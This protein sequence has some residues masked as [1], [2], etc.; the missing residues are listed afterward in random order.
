MNLFDLQDYTYVKLDR[1]DELEITKFG[2]MKPGMGFLKLI[3]AKSC[4]LKKVRV[5]SDMKKLTGKASCR[6]CH[7][8]FSV[9][10]TGINVYF[11]FWYVKIYFYLKVKQIMLN[12]G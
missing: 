6:I 11:Y 10:V 7:Q 4:M 2:N 9:T 5:C 12:T 1:L 3:L 8:N